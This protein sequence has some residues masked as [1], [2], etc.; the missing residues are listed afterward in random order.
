MASPFTVEL[1]VHLR[2]D[3]VIAT[4]ITLRK[5]FSVLIQAPMTV[6]W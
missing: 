6:S 4:M 5:A 3:S 2:N 1:I